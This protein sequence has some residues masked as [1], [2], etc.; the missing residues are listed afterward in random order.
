MPIPTG[1]PAGR[2]ANS[3]GSESTRSATTTV[4]EAASAGSMPTI[5]STRTAG[6]AGIAGTQRSR[7]T[8]TRASSAEPIP[9]FPSRSSSGLWATVKVVVR[10]AA[11]QIRA[12]T[13]RS[14]S[15]TPSSLKRSGSTKPFH[16]IS[17]PSSAFGV[18]PERA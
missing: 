9:I 14:A 2:D 12:A 17:S 10:A 8:R 3:F 11:R 13:S 5:R 15:K 6:S 7:C 16:G 18:V 1:G 4:T